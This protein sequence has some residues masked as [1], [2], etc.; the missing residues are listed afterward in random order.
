MD[1]T[2]AKENKNTSCISNHLTSD[3]IFSIYN[4]FLSCLDAENTA[5]WQPGHYPNLHTPASECITLQKTRRDGRL[6]NLPWALLT[7][8]D[9]II[10]CPGQQ[11][12][13]SC[14]PSDVCHFN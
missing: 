7:R 11:A 3:R 12:P 14:I 8:G 5:V 2:K 9:I 13:G 1:L 10:L 6:I 4:N